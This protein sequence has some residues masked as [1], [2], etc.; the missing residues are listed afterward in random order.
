MICGLNETPP[1]MKIY[2]ILVLSGH[3]LIAQIDPAVCFFDPF[4]CL[5]E[6]IFLL[7]LVL[8]ALP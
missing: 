8:Y 5:P 3:K 2:S 1:L 7:K 4:Y 6:M